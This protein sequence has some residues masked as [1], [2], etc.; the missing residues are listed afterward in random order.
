VGQQKGELSFSFF[1]LV[2]FGWK[3]SAACAATKYNQTEN[4]VLIGSQ[5]DSLILF[6]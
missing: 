3:I 6:H 2:P 4:D 1:Y 5:Y